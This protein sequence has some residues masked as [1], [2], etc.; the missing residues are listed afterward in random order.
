MRVTSAG[1]AAFALTLIGLGILGFIRGDFSPIWQPVWKGLPGRELLAYLC[2]LVCVASGLGLLSRRVAAPAARLLLGCLL[3]W[4]LVFKAPTVVRA[5]ADAAS[6]ES[7]G[8]TVVLVS[9]AWVLYA[10]FV[11]AVHPRRLAFASG[12]R[13]VRI[14]RVFYGLAMLAFGVAHLA[15]VKFT[16]SLVPA[17]LPSH[18]AW[19][20]F[21]G[22]AYLAAGAAVLIGVCARLAAALSTLQMGLFTLLVWAPVLAAGSKDPSAWS[23][24]ILSWV[25]TAAGLGVAESYRGKPW[26]A[27]GTSP[28]PRA[29][30]AP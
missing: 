24:G 6:W 18:V 1:T 10:W 21:T 4:L 9:A 29:A 30:G 15:Y 5:P 22:Y 14:A 11:G 13:G 8:E 28:A 17:W 26:L 7:C 19:V 3:L 2:A 27:L 23:E 12:E 25:L 16:A 20:Y